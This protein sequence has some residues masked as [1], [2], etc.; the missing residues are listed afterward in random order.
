MKF[1]SRTKFMSVPILKPNESKEQ[2]YQDVLEN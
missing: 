1:C 2:I